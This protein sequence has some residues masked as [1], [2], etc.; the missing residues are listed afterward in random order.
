MN[1]PDSN[2]LYNGKFT[3]GDPLTGLPASQDSAEHMNA[4]YD[5]LIA[6]IVASGLNPDATIKG[7]VLAAINNIRKDDLYDRTSDYLATQGRKNLLINGT[8]TI[9][10]RGDSFSATGYAADRW[11]TVL[12]SATC[13]RD[14][15][16]MRVDISS[17]GGHCEFRQALENRVV[18]KL[19]GQ[20]LTFSVNLQSENAVGNVML[21]VTWSDS[22][23][24]QLNI[25]A[26]VAEESFKLSPDFNESITFTVP[27]TAV[28]LRVN[29]ISDAQ[30]SEAKIWLKNSQLEFGR[31]QTH[32]EFRHESEEMLLCKRYGSLESFDNYV[33]LGNIYLYNGNK[34]GGISYK[35]TTPMRATPSVTIKS[36][37]VSVG[38][39][40]ATETVTS[41]SANAI[42]NNNSSI[43][44]LSLAWTTAY[45][46]SQAY[47]V[48][49]T[50]FLD[51][52]L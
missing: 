49:L 52:E 46:Y 24:A 37:A 21:S 2:D 19:R 36:G 29:I 15:I 35:L 13:S 14:D 34:G 41:V 26:V 4:I 10:Q 48:R 11:Y 18:K 42:S 51:A 27:A 22:T 8:P 6:L 7:Q 16:G 20:E 33:G 44:G 9:W 39:S 32:Y 40:S 12:S 45:G 50:L 28:G 5:E 17:A 23:D 38:E 25:A 31:R 3:D 1:Y 43:I 30:N 47:G